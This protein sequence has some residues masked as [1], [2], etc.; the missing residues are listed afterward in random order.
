[1]KSNW[2]RWQSIC[3]CWI[4]KDSNSNSIFLIRSR[5]FCMFISKRIRAMLKSIHFKLNHSYR[6]VQNNLF[7]ANKL[8]TNSITIFVQTNWIFYNHFNNSC[9]PFQTMSVRLFW[10]QIWLCFLPLIWFSGLCT[11]FVIPC[12]NLALRL[13]V[14]K[15]HHTNVLLFHISIYCTV[16]AH[17]VWFIWFFCTYRVHTV[18]LSIFSRAWKIFVVIG[19]SLEFSL[20]LSPYI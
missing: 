12:I 17:S 16:R 13:I 8:F 9:R 11:Y 15:S 2:T 19:D 20:S 1:M 6:S 7:C 4:K 5:Y 3:C 10:F 18:R 14:L